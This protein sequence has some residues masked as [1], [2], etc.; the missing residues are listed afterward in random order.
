M[1]RELDTVVLTHDLEEHGLKQ[2][3]I[4]AV[5]HC[6]KGGEDFEVEFMTAEG[7]TVAL[8]TL[9]LADIRPMHGREILHAREYV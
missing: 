9:S 4:G 6:H 3:D 7:R 5:V 1:I 2:G 8:L